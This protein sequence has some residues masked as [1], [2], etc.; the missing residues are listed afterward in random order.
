MLPFLPEEEAA[1]PPVPTAV[2][3]VRPLGDIKPHTAPGAGV[4]ADGVADDGGG[5]GGSD[6]M[7]GDNQAGWDESPEPPKPGSGPMR[8]NVA[9]RPS[10]GKPM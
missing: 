8:P 7:G 9:A 4:M 3:V 5:G 6:S 2:P 10:T 1:P